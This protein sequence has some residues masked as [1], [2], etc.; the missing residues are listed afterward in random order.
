MNHP[1]LFV[2]VDSGTYALVEWGFSQV[3]TYPDIIASVLKST[4]KPLSADTIYYKVNEIRQVKRSTLLMSL[5]M[6]PRFYRSLEKTYGLRI[7]LPPREKQTL[8]TP[9]WLVEESDSYKRLEQAS[10]KGY[11]VEDMILTDLSNA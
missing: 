10:Q 11:K 4:N 9:E 6:H 3:D 2:R 7:W 5:D 1:S 8:R